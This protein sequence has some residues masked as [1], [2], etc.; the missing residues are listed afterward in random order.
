MFRIRGWLHL[1][2]MRFLT[3]SLL[4]VPRIDLRKGERFHF[5]V[6]DINFATFAVD[7]RQSCL[8]GV[9]RHPNFAGPDVGRS[10]WNEAHNAMLPFSIHNAVD[11]LVQGAIAAIAYHQVIVFL[12]SF[13]CQFH[14]M[15][16]IFFNRDIGAPT[17]SREYGQYIGE[18]HY[19]LPGARINH[20]TCLF[21]THIKNAPILRDMSP[22]LYVTYHAKRSSRVS[23]YYR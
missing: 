8:D 7:E 17:S 19:V 3:G 6:S 16:A 9:N 13:G 12:S 5:D 22:V 11:Y 20:D 4:L 18:F 23:V 1:L 15:P 21:T 10:S 2:L 14:G